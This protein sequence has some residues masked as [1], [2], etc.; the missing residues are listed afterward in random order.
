M[1]PHEEVYSWFTHPV[2]N[3]YW[4]HYQQAMS[5]QQK[6]R[7]AYRRALLA[8]SC[9]PF[10]QP[11]TAATAPPR[12]SDWHVGEEAGTRGAGGRQGHPSRKCTDQ[13]S[14][15]SET[16][17][18]D[19]GSDG[20]IECDVSNMEITEEL[21]QYFAQTEKHREELKR[22][23]QLEAE[24]EDAYVLADQDLHRVSWRSALPPAERPGER[25]GAEMKKLYGEDAAKI[26]GME[27]A[28]QL[29]FDRNCDRKQPKY[30]PVIPLKL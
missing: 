25:R 10:F 13:V 28:M 30:W 16:D 2:Y 8:Y 7:Q 9:P 23:Q 1:D 26:Q 19:S 15:D 27:T 3:R 11:T 14:S 20:E 21:R 24:K 5:W 29:T 6:H 12:Y 18:E 22:Q 4:Q 17:K